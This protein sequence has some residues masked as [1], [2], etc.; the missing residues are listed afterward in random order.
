MQFLWYDLETFGRDARRSRIAQFAAIRTDEHLRPVEAPLS[1]FCQ[2]TDD[3][4][5]S[6]GACLITGITPQQ[7]L[8][9]G[10]PEAEFAAR[11]HEEMSKPD[12][13]AAGYNSIRFDDEFIRH[14]FYRNFFDPYAR[15][16]RNGNSRWDLIDAVRMA[17]ALR[18][19]GI[20][21]PVRDDGAPSFKLEHLAAA[22]GLVHSH[23]HEALSDVEATI[24]L[25]ARLKSAHGRLFD[26]ALALREKKRAGALLDYADMTPVLHISQR[27]PAAEGCGRLVLPI[28][29]HPRIA[30]RIIVCDLRDDPS[31]IIELAA[32]DIRDRLYIARADLPEDVARIGLK[33]IHLNRAPILVELRHLDPTQLAVFGI[34]LP[35]QLEHAARLRTATGLADKLRE[36]FGAPRPDTVPDDPELALYDGFPAPADAALFARV[37]ECGGRPPRGGTFGFRDPRYEELAFRY[38][39]RI[40]PQAL[41]AAEHARWQQYRRARLAPGSGLAECDLPTYRAEIAALRAGAQPGSGAHALLDA[42]EAWGQQAENALD[43]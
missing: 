25:A 33:E 18:P 8:A 27:Y 42:L 23:A 24:A 10:L 31:A 19:D 6:P 40:W 15:E 38:R 5:P 11:I 35:R 36:V 29:P 37:R 2:P 20:T 17:R 30:N 22:N 3:F 13:C 7:A 9:D 34:D 43:G 41:D 4:L 26:Y 39:A 16:W 32:P 21:W 1:F 28:C 12:T 14:L